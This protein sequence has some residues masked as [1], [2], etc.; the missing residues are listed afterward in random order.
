[1]TR[2]SLSLLGT[3]QATLDG[4][5]IAAFES[6]KVRALLSYLAVESDRPHRRETL[7]ALLWPDRPAPNARQNLSQAL[8]NLRR[9]IGDRKANPPFLFITQQ[10]IQFNRDADY[11]LDVT[12]FEDR[13]AASQKHPHVELTVCTPCLKRLDRAMTQYR[14]EF[15]AGFS[16][17]DSLSFDEWALLK[18]EQL[19][20]L[21]L[22][23]L[24]S[25]TVA[26]EIQGA[27]EVALPYAWRK[28]EF[29]PWNEEGQQRLLQ[30]LAL[31]GQRSAALA[32]YEKFRQ[33]LWHDLDVEPGEVTQLL[34]EDIR[35]GKLEKESVHLRFDKPR[36]NLPAHLTPFIGRESELE[37]IKEKFDDPECRLLTLVGPGGIGKTRL[38][39]QAAGNLLEQY[40]HGVWFVDLSANTGSEQVLAS[41]ANTLQVPEVASEPRLMT[42]KRALGQKQMLLLI[43]N[44]EH[45]IEAA[46]ALSELLAVAPG[47]ALM[48][49]SREVLRLEGEHVYLVAPLGLPEMQRSLSAAALSQYEA[50]RLFLDR[51]R[52]VNPAFALTEENAPVVAEICVRLEG[53]P[54][55]IELAAGRSRLFTPEQLS[56]QLKNRLRTLVGGARNRP[57]RHQTLRITFEWSYQLLNDS[58]KRLFARLGAFAGGWT[59]EAAESVC[60]P[61]LPVDVLGGMESLLDKSLIRQSQPGA[62]GPRFTM[63][64]TIREFAVEK[65]VESGQ[66][67]LIHGRH[68]A[69]FLEWIRRPKEYWGRFMFDVQA[70]EVENVRAVMHRGLA[71]GE[72]DAPVEIV[73]LMYYLWLFRGHAVEMGN[74][75]E[76]VLA[77]ESSWS[78]LPPKLHA[79]ALRIAGN[80]QGL[81]ALDLQKGFRYYEQSLM[82]SRSEQDQQ[83]M[84][85][86]LFNLAILHARTG[87]YALA[88]SLNEEALAH[89]EERG[90]LSRM[91]NVLGN[92]AEHLADEGAFEPAWAYAEKGLERDE[93]QEP[94][95]QEAVMLQIMG[96]MAMRQENYETARGYLERALAIWDELGS[97][98]AQTHTRELLGVLALKENNLE[99]AER[100]LVQALHAYAEQHLRD[101]VPATLDRVAELRFAQGKTKEAARIYAAVDAFNSRFGL[102][103]PPVK[104]PMYEQTLDSA[105]QQLGDA[106]FRSAWREGESWDLFDLARK[107]VE[108]RRERT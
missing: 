19:H 5:P 97:D 31:N 36:H 23:V 62:G 78:S 66:Q 86:T 14:G 46:P 73:C 99:D 95:G 24:V 29:D 6:D 54:L 22:E 34:A 37:K 55:A 44:F 58:E 39:V 3:W 85:A 25:L 80:L 71:S 33:L 74:W 10:T 93:N 4:A 2:L 7:A 21:V 98:L 81:L 30:L 79:L 72:L 1:M 50:V 17:S 100:L 75:L 69:Y 65:L 105:R 16:V 40:I 52:S 35:S 45:L 20:R 28:A 47:L 57:N 61:G 87:N 64:E 56:A 104:V 103:R 63:L 60:A 18:R 53:L 15:L 12:A 11:L 32:Q 96:S 43:D 92:L 102:A 8:S 68:V 59:L 101:P 13:I 38:A 27:F 108:E 91:R 106:A 107:L 26:Y 82:I 9:G 42:L 51:I 49:T 48:V 90:L 77:D 84:A 41:V 76:E 88:Q 94:E 67:T 70:L 89:T 83:S